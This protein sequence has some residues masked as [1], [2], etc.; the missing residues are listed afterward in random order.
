L[1][2]ELKRLAED[3]GVCLASCL[4]FWQDDLI[5]QAFNRAMILAPQLYGSPW[6]LRDDEFPQLARI[7][8]L[9]RRYRDI[10]TRGM[11]LPENSYRPHAVSRGDGKTRLITLRNLTWEPVTH[12]VALSASSR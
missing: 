9:H 4:D 1:P 12:R 2:P 7:F 5:L 8:N 3:H 10:L 6:F 11:V